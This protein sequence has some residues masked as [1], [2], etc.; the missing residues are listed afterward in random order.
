[1]RTDLA[2]L[3]L[4]EGGF[5]G[6]FST[7]AQAAGSVV[8]AL[9]LIVGGTWA[10]FKFAKGRTFQPRL[11]VT[12]TGQWIRV[13]GKDVLQV[14]ATATNIGSSMIAIRQQGTG[15]M[16][17]RLS[18]EQPDPPASVEWERIG[19]VHELFADHSW[20]EPSE[21]VTDELLLSL[22]LATPT[23]VRIVSRVVCERRRKKNVVIFARKIVHA[24]AS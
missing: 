2:G 1:M 4:E 16:V 8:T 24:E 17:N 15:L 21:S 18:A 6:T 10:Y 19:G 22:G 11:Q 13:A 7:V 12:L 3:L 20:I 5:L 9:A 23:T 14:N